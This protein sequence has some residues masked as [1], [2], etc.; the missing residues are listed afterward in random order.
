MAQMYKVF[1]QHHRLTV[2]SERP[3]SSSGI[4]ISDTGERDAWS[5]I[6]ANRIKNNDLEDWEII[7]EP[8]RFL[9]A[10]WSR[11]R[12]IEAA[13]GRV[14]DR[15]GR[16]LMIYRLGH[17]DLPKGKIEAGELPLEAAAREI[18]EECGLSAL[19]MTAELDCSY[20]IYRQKGVWYLKKTH[21]F[22]FQISN[23]Q[24]L[25]P[26]AEEGIEKI[27]WL[28]TEEIR[29]RKDLIY[30]SLYALLPE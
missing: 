19:E 29:D 24:E 17:W 12:H 4:H 7:D 13:G 28:D 21:W 9:E 22:Q 2:S 11:F 6:I 16:I 8:E 5:E 1:I 25:I 10:L 15:F 27:E 14:H 18:E 26:Q 20:H 30:P 3:I 23:D